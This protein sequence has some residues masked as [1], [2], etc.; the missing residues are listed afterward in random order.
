[1]QRS[2]LLKSTLVAFWVIGLSVQIPPSFGQPS[3]LS[4]KDGQLPMNFNRPSR[5]PPRYEESSS[6]LPASLFRTSSS[7]YGVQFTR[8][9][10][11]AQEASA[12]KALVQISSFFLSEGK[13]NYHKTGSGVI[14][15]SSGTVLTNVHVIRDTGQQGCTITIPNPPRANLLVI[16]IQDAEPPV[17][18]FAVDLRGLTG[19]ALARAILAEDLSLDLAILRINKR[20]AGKEPPKNLQEL[21]KAVQDNTLEL[22]DLDEPVNLESL[23]LWDTAAVEV[24]QDVQLAGYPAPK[25]ELP[26]TRLTFT[27]GPVLEKHPEGTM[28]L[29]RA[30]ATYGF[31]GG[32]LIEKRSGFAIGILCGGQSIETPAGPLVLAVGRALDAKVQQLLNKVP[33]IKRRPVPRFTLTP[34][35]PK[36]G[37]TVTFDASDS[38]DPDGRISKYEWDLDSDGKP[39]AE[40]GQVQ[41]TFQDDA[42]VTLIVIDSDGLDAQ[43]T[44]RVIL[45]RREQ[46]KQTQQ[47]CKPIQIGART[48]DTIRD[49]IEAAQPEETITVGPGTCQ[50]N[51]VITKSLKLQGAGR[52][53]TILLGDGRAPVI[54]VCPRKTTGESACPQP[55]E[56]TIEGFTIRNGL[57][58][59]QALANAKV[60]VRESDLL[61]SVQQGVDAAFGA[62]VTLVNNRLSRNDEEGFVLEG[63]RAEL[64]GNTISDNGDE[65]VLIKNLRTHNKFIPAEAQLAGNT[66]DSNEGFGVFVTQSASVKI[67]GSRISRSGSNGLEA[68]EQANVKVVDTEIQENAE[69][70]VRLFD[71]TAEITENTAISGNGRHGLSVRGSATVTL[72]YSTVSDNRWDGLWVRDSAKVSLLET[73]VSDNKSNGLSVG[74]S[75][76]VTLTNSQ[77]SGNEGDG[78]WV[79]TSARVEIRDSVIKDNKGTFSDGL[80][81]RALA[82]VILQNTMV[83][84]NKLNG[85]SV[86]D[87]ATVTLVNSQVTNNGQDGIE[88][89]D[90]A[91]VTLT[92]DS[93]ISSNDV[94]GL[95]V[96]GSAR[97]ILQDTT[98]SANGTGLMVGGSATVNLKNAT[99]L[100]N[101]VGLVVGITARVTLSNKTTISRNYDGLRVLQKASMTLIDVQ[102]SFNRQDGLFVSDEATTEIRDSVIEYNDRCGIYVLSNKAKVQ[103]SPNEMRINGADLCGYA[104]FSVR[105]PLVPQTDRKEIHIP[106]D[107]PAMKCPPSQPVQ[108]AIDAV[109]PGGVIVLAALAFEEGLTI[110]K[111]LTLR[112]AGQEQTYLRAGYENNL[113]VSIPSTVNGAVLEELTITGSDLDGLLIYGEATLRNVTVSDNAYGLSILDAATVTLQETQVSENKY[114]GLSMVD[115]AQVTLASS[116]VFDN[117]GYGLEVGDSAQVTLKSSQVSSNKWGG[118]LVVD[119]AR[120]TLIDKTMVSDNGMNGL[121]VVRTAIVILQDTEISG[122]RWSGLSVEDSAGVKILNSRIFGNQTYGIALEFKACGFSDDGFHGQVEGSGN[123]IHDNGRLDL[124]PQDFPWPKDFVIPPSPGL[125]EA[126]VCPSGCPFASI[127]EAVRAVRPGGTIRV[128]AGIYSQPIV[129]AKTLTLLGEGADKV[130]IQ[131]MEGIG[132]VIDHEEPITVTI[133]GVTISQ[134]QRDGIEIRS[135]ARVTLQDM[136]VFNNHMWGI[137]IEDS[138]TVSLQNVQISGNGHGLSVWGSARVTLTNSRISDN[139]WGNGLSAR[140][141]AQVTLTNTQISGNGDNGI[142]VEDLAM[143]ILVRSTFSNNRKC[144]VKGYRIFGW[145]NTFFEN[146]TDICDSDKQRLSRTLPPDS[147]SR[148]YIAVPRDA[149][150]LQQAIDLVAEGGIITIAPGTYEETLEILNKSFVLRGAGLD[151]VNL[152]SRDRGSAILVFADEAKEVQLRGLTIGPSSR[153]GLDVW[154]LGMVTLAN[155]KISDNGRNGISVGDV[156]QVILQDTWVSG[157]KWYGL[158]IRD[159]GLVNLQNSQI[160]SNGRNGLQICPLLTESECTAQVTLTNS[161]SFTN[162]G[163]GLFVGD[164]ARVILQNTQISSNELYGLDIVDLAMVNLKNVTIFNNKSNGLNVQ[165]L[166]K[167]NLQD[168]QVSNN[169]WYGFLAEHSAKASLTNVEVSN[170]RWDGLLVKDLAV[171]EVQRST[172]EG[173]GT[174]PSCVKPDEICNG[175]V[176]AEH[177]QATIVDSIIR[178]NTDWGV[179][180][181]LTKCGYSSDVFTGQVVMQ[182]TNTI[183]GNNKSGNQ[184]GMGNPGEHPWNR[185][186]VPDGQV[187]LP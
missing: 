45:G 68:D 129:I 32:A 159:S 111:P 156:A 113:I 120:V 77:V 108:C 58:A 118:L 119:S 168:V 76:Q 124:C 116:R 163:S 25:P 80:F 72:T 138:A 176:I 161:Q 97:V 50:E 30:F 24:G 88:A 145:E 167:V 12:E 95:L 100:S 94:R 184:N 127:P 82:T 101:D 92:A 5:L 39:D 31:S 135:K 114:G 130:L 122:N 46:L 74:G 42:R 131:G 27:E 181:W 151:Q 71:A 43:R 186:E 83:S 52:E 182:G 158:E 44:Q 155:A 59:L 153:D 104:P 65:G 177:S 53:K 169:G 175:I 38:F 56:V 6:L 140:V 102:I 126:E 144:G 28:V 70:G 137:S 164:L 185:P 81:I 165:H 49:A 105:K 61:E 85:L 73:S 14:V 157:N 170:N 69:H 143:A 187:C 148:L 123:E 54:A 1:M 40:G 96:L 4:Q 117:G 10:T 98:V 134:A 115:S 132:I 16:L 41:R 139:Y 79:V 125:D 57:H 78:L 180:V 13:Y 9:A 171:V 152:Q 179:A 91:Q 166:A 150:S 109:A 47:Q 37:E 22:A 3:L 33:E 107:F 15:H 142:E 121:K 36:P 178:N 90:S 110:W 35:F 8:H 128:R 7:A 103:G 147:H 60:T 11:S 146:G 55:V 66:I 64:Q 67:Q 162:G 29:D 34:E 174:D 51:L 112:G 154:G 173:N 160:S 93:R 106:S 62:D 23:P 172:I 17:P 21:V 149:S 19:E 18:K 141:L 89:K 75:A 2:L 86:W 87:S 63:G 136:Q 99:V 26:L 183:E 20:I 48:F 84:G 133:A